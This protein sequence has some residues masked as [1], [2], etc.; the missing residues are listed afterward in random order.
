MVALMCC[1]C[2]H[3]IPELPSETH[4]GANTFGCLVNGELVVPYNDSFFLNGKDSPSASYISDTDKLQ[5]TAYGQNYQPFYFTVSAP[6]TG[7][8]RTIDAVKYYLH[9]YDS[10]YYGGNNIGEISFSYF[11]PERKIVSG[12][13]WFI[14]YRYNY[15]SDQPIDNNDFV[16]VTL[17][18][19]DIKF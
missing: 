13:F 7:A 4:S 8:V 19:F 1:A 17:G 3:R 16:T 14:G 2:K 9:E 15:D 5:I 10:Y 11:S 6:K 12:T 18:R